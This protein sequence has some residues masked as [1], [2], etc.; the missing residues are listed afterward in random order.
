M[1]VHSIIRTW[2]LLSFLMDKMVLLSDSLFDLM[3]RGLLQSSCVKQFWIIHGLN[4]FF[5][6]GFIW[7]LKWVGNFVN[8][9][10][11]VSS[12]PDS[13]WIALLRPTLFFIWISSI[14][15]SLCSASHFL[16]PAIWSPAQK[17][18]LSCFHISQLNDLFLQV[19]CILV[20]IYIGFWCDH[21]Y[22][23]CGRS[24]VG[25]GI[26]RLRSLRVRQG[27]TDCREVCLD[28]RLV[29]VLQLVDF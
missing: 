13:I 26:G 22:S 15:L 8:L 2:T 23:N 20:L 17:G 4:F 11:C 1:F 6:S 24:Y 19:F 10:A 29:R 5:C 9:F 28:W 3:V 7:Q 25:H 16:L 27:Y 18:H 12:S 14:F 21:T